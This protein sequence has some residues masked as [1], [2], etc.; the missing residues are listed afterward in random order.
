MDGGFK[1]KGICSKLVLKR[2]KLERFAVENIKEVM[3]HPHH[4]ERIEKYP[5]LMFKKSLTLNGQ[6]VEITRGSSMN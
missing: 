3:T 4:L 1:N 2:D 6:N 5:D